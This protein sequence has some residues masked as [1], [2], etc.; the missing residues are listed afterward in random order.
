MTLGRSLTRRIAPHVGRR[1]AGARARSWSRSPCCSPAGV[2]R[3]FQAAIADDLPSGLVNP[4]GELEETGAVRRTLARV[5]DGGAGRARRPGTTARRCSGRRAGARVRR[6]STR[7]FNTRASRST[8][9]GLRGRV[10]LI[11]FWTYTCIN[12]LRT[13]PHLRAWDARYRDAGLTIVGVHTPEFAFER[14]AGNVARRRRGERAALPGRA[15]QRLRHL[16]RVAEPVLAGQVPD[17]RARPRPLLALRR[18]RLRGD[19]AGDPGAARRGGR[20]R[21]AAT[22]PTWRRPTGRRPA[23]RRRRPTS[24]GSGPRGSWTRADV[25][26]GRARFAT[27]PVALAPGPVR[28]SA[29]AGR[30]ARAGRGR[31]AARGSRRTSARR[32]SSSCSAAAAPG[33]RVAAGAARRPAAAR[34]AAQ[35]RRRA[36]ASSA[37]GDAAALQA[38]PTWGGSRRQRLDA[39]RSTRASPATRSRSARTGRGLG[40]RLEP[41]VAKGVHRRAAAPRRALEEAAL[42]Q[43]GL[44]DVLDRVGLLLHGDR[45]RGEADRA[46]GEA[47]ADDR[48]GSRGRCG[49]AR[50]SSTPIRSSAAPATVASIAPSQRT[51]A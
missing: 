17:R 8:L 44:V 15:R 22:A 6:Q 14:D 16:E 19:R 30:R 12:C 35:G 9:R 43:V 50:A 28:A 7:W 23:S 41:E 1:P 31:C 39:R 21:P 27:G 37:S 13:L 38:R 3:D 51:S 40:R 46:A 32:R 48:R 18:G 42:E 20:G 10:V 25:Q 36:A 2:D 49:R 47:L 4:S 29:G 5:R 24:A 33:K 45:E 11:D 26:L 34:S